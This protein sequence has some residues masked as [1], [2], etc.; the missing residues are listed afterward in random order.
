MASALVV[1]LAGCTV[2]AGPGGTR[3]G[4][5]LAT[6]N[7]SAGVPVVLRL[8]DRGATATLVDTPQARQLTAMLPVTVRL[9]DVW[10]QAKSGRLPHGLT[11]EGGPTVHRP[12]P[13]EIY[14]WPQTEVIA[15]YYADR[16]QPVP[17]P[18]LV[19]LGVV[20]TGLEILAE[21]GR[22]FTVRIDV[23]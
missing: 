5:P 10:A 16:D 17:G 4:S 1:V 12:V 3:F 20:D 8:D 9:Q 13:G 2:T 18:G 21:A 7:A 23:A 14:F 15:I 22:R 19:R 6:L 11:V